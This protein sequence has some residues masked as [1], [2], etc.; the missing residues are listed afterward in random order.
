M[1]AVR[2]DPLDVVGNAPQAAVAYAVMATQTDTVRKNAIP[3]RIPRHS[4]WNFGII[5]AVD[6]MSKPPQFNVFYMLCNTSGNG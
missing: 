4:S 5:F 3:M 6:D 2:P 1:V